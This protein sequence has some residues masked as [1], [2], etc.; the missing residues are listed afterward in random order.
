[1][2]GTNYI[3]AFAATSLLL[4]ATI[5]VPVAAAGPLEN[6]QVTAVSD[7]SA[8]FQIVV[9]DIDDPDNKRLYF[10]YR[11][12]RTKERKHTEHVTPSRKK[13]HT[14]SQYG[15]NPGTEYQVRAFLI[16]QN[17]DVLDYSRSVSFTTEGDPPQDSDEVSSGLLSPILDTLKNLPD[18]IVDAFFGIFNAAAEAFVNLLTHVIVAHPTVHPNEDV[19]KIHHRTFLASLLLSGAASMVIGILLMLGYSEVNGKPTA[20]HIGKLVLAMALAAVAPALVQYAVDFSHALTVAFRPASPGVLGTALLAVELVIVGF[21]NA[22]LLLG[23]ATTFVVRDLY[24]L[25]FAAAAPFIFLL[26]ATPYFNRFSQVLIG[27]FWGFILIGPLEM[28]AFSLTLSLLEL[29]GMELPSWLLGFGGIVFMFVLPLLIVPA[30]WA[31]VGTAAGLAAEAGGMASSAIRASRK[32]RNEGTVYDLDYLEA[33]EWIDLTRR[34][35]RPTKY[36]QY[37]DRQDSAIQ[38]PSLYLDYGLDPDHYID[39]KEDNDER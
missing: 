12:Q 14:I 19:S 30:S 8:K 35:K 10:E 17:G 6:M 11:N 15:L 32:N 18:N 4:L 9:G 16:D 37:Y 34:E 38:D 24:F 5:A 26:H 27:T 31:M 7:D 1:M 2:K 20:H 13:H 21:L 36:S 23:I 39:T 25:F 22:F 29:N 3:A 33:M 28:I